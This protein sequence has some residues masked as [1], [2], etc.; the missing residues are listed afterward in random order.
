[1]CL[2]HSKDWQDKLVLPL[3]AAGAELLGV[4]PRRPGQAAAPEE[5]LDAV[6]LVGGAREPGGREH[7]EL[8][9]RVK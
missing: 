2:H 6:A 3:F 8:N 4:Q 5:V 1:M 7:T 9:R